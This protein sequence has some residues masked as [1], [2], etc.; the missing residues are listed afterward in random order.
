MKWTRVVRAAALLFTAPLAV[1]GQAIP[2]ELIYALIGGR[3]LPVRVVVGQIPP[4]FPVDF[5]LPSEARVVGGTTTGN[6]DATLIIVLAGDPAAVRQRVSE[7]VERSGWKAI[8]IPKEPARPTTEQQGVVE[9]TI[10]PTSPFCKGDAR[11]V[12]SG[13]GRPPQEYWTR[14]INYIRLDYTSRSGNAAACQ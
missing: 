11:L 7:Y 14:N 6:R 4:N 5:K 2:E 8:P 13:A 10:P 12:I 3:G 1:H 9:A